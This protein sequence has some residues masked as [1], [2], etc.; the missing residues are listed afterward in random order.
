MRQVAALLAAPSLA[1]ALTAALA[2]SDA[3]QRR[4]GLWRQELTLDNGSHAIPISEMCSRTATH[5][6]GAQMDRARCSIYR[7]AASNGKFRN[8]FA[9]AG[10][11]R[12]QR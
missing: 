12:D 2:A 1:Y 6:V 7:I 4:L 5:L 10:P 9:N 11:A 3:P 8:V